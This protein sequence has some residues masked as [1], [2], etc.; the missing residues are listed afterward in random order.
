MNTQG[1]EQTAELSCQE[2]R[3]SELNQDEAHPLSSGWKSGPG[4]QLQSHAAGVTDKLVLSLGQETRIKQFSGHQPESPRKTE[5][6]HLT[7]SA[8]QPKAVKRQGCKRLDQSQVAHKSQIQVPGSAVREEPVELNVSPYTA[9][10]EGNKEASA[11]E[12]SILL[13]TPYFPNKRCAMED[14]MTV[15]FVVVWSKNF[16]FEER[17]GK[18]VVAAYN[19][20]RRYQEIARMNKRFENNCGFLVVGQATIP[21][22]DLQ[23]RQPI[24]YKYGVIDIFSGTRAIQLEHIY[25]TAHK[26]EKAEFHRVLAVPESAIKAGGVW[27]QF[28]DICQSR[29]GSVSIGKSKKTASESILQFLED[30]LLKDLSPGKDLGDVERKLDCY[31]ECFKTSSIGDAEQKISDLK[32]DID[33]LK[34][35]DYIRKFI[36]NVLGN[37]RFR[38]P[39]SAMDVLLFVLCTVVHHN[40]YIS[41][42]AM[43]KIEKMA[44]NVDSQKDTFMNLKE[45]RKRKCISALKHVCIQSSKDSKSTC[46]IWLLPLLYAVQ[47]D[48]SEKAEDPLTSQDTWSLPFAQLRREEEKQMKVLAMINAHQTFI[49]SCAPL[50]EKV[51]EMLA[52]KNFCREPVPHIHVPLQLLLNNVYQRITSRLAE[53]HGIN[54]FQESDVN[55]VLKD[56]ARRTKAWL[57]TRHQTGNAED[58]LQ[59]KK[60]ED[61]LQCLNLILALVTIFLK[62]PQKIPFSPVMT[63]LQIWELFSETEDLLQTKRDFRVLKQTQGLKEFMNVAESW[64]QELFPKSSEQEKV[65]FH[66]IDMWDQLISAGLFCDEW[67]RDWRKHI[68]SLFAEWLKRVS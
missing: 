67:T 20:P 23:S 57:G 54:S 31:K 48:P 44:Q 49:G 55:V 38:H 40:I 51:I 2:R 6:D 13:E 29:S 10:R 7:G 15:E 19:S 66:Y 63:S 8:S 34:V 33:E 9:D 46:W 1:A 14:T 11:S 47:R 37:P 5:I 56:I 62:H 12:E 4:S 64:I 32:T 18:I 68:K 16:V 45:P 52:L 22:L 24:Y 58:V 27:T 39:I 59:P 21:V 3:T 50:A 60:L 25:K 17:F 65:F 43:S 41:A 35:Y 36:E 28:D 42:E 30:E 26:N 53:G 61:V